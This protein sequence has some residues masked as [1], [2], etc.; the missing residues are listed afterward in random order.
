MCRNAIRHWH[1]GV[2]MAHHKAR[3]LIAADKFAQPMRA[4]GRD[5]ATTATRAPSGAGMPQGDK[6]R[7]IIRE[8]DGIG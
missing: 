2:Q 1:I 6:Q 8:E 7:G 4:S 3:C 5:K